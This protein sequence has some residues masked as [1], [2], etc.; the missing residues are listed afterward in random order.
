MDVLIRTFPQYV[1]SKVSTDS[2]EQEETEYNYVEEADEYVP[3]LIT[4]DNVIDL[5]VERIRGSVDESQLPLVRRLTQ[6]IIDAI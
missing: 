6:E 3:I 2:K 5:L 1:W 4:P